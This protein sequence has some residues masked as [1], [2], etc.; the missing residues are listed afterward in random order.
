M[1]LLSGLLAS[2]QLEWL[3]NLEGVGGIHW[4][5]GHWSQEGV[6]GVRV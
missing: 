1:F 3:G 6:L 5:L 4:G 2:L